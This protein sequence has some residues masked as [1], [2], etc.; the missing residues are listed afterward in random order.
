MPQNNYMEREIREKGLPLNWEEKQRKAESRQAK[1]ISKQAHKL[2]GIK[3]KIFSKERYKEKVNIKKTIKAHEEKKADVK[4]KGT[5]KESVPAYLMDRET[6]NSNKILSNMVKQKRKEKAGKWEVPIAKVKAMSEAEMFSI[7]KTGKRGKKAWKRII[8]KATFVPEDFTRKPPKYERFVR[9][10]GMR[11]KRAHVTHPE[12]KTTFYLDIVGVKRN[13]QSALYTNLG[14]LTKGAVIEVNVTDL[15]LVTQ[16]G[17]VV[18]S[19]YAQI[20][21][22]PENDGC[23]NAVLL[24]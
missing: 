21:N 24:V 9:P 10:T 5:N 16:T 8:T 18:L 14:V 22:N 3:A 15:G 19:K 23:V 6:T 12:L 2:R 4:T 20:T 13:P 17:K 1:K 7:L 11:F